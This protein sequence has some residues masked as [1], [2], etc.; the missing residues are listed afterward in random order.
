MSLSHVYCVGITFECGTF[1]Y[2]SMI[3]AQRLEGKDQTPLLE[4]KTTNS[5]EQKWL[6]EFTTVWTL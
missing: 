2:T 6:P 5:L 4:E 1:L 3:N